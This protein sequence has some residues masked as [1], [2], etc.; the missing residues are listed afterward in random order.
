MG[1]YLQM[2][3]QTENLVGET[4]LDNFD[5]IVLSPLNRLPDEL[6][7]DIPTYRKVKNFDIVLDPQLYYPKTPKNKIREHPY[8]PSDFDSS[9]HSSLKWWEQINNN[10]M[11]YA[12]ELGVNTVVSPVIDPSKCSIDYY[13]NV[14]DVFN[15]L[16]SK[17]QSTV[18]K[19]W[20]ALIIDINDIVDDN[21]LME[22]ASFFGM[23]N[24]DGFYIIFKSDIEPRREYS[25]E[26][27]IK[28]MLKFINELKILNKEIMISFSSSDMILFKAAGASHCGTGKFF[29]LR[30]FTKSRFEEPS[31]GG[32]Q[33]PYFF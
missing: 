28:A 2:G 14:F 20:A 19:I 27:Q 23:F 18:S 11:D 22:L 17:K 3:H 30:R 4:D 9:D 12:I 8:F 33:L 16:Y 24:S 13:Q 10:L 1:S 25:E 29:N 5:G 32:G 6:K 26:K 31:G 7:I 15:H 21:F